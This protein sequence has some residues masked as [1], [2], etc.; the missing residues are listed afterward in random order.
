MKKILFFIAFAMSLRSLSAQTYG[1]NY[2]AIVRDGSGKI[3]A[4]QP[5]QLRFQILNTANAKLYEETHAD[6]TDAFGRVVSVVG[7]GTAVSGKF[8]TLNWA[9]RKHF[10]GVAIK[11][12]GAA[13]WAEL[14]KE[15]IV[16]SP[17]ARGNSDWINS[18]TNR[19]T[20]KT[21]RLWP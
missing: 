2:Q 11:L 6:T 3:A 18:S 13:G 20:P 1:Y 7:S 21:G 8:D 17:F 19:K 5:V 10:L 12:G 4:N 15:E 9:A 14:G 16:L